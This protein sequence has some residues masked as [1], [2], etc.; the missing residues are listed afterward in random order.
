MNTLKLEIEGASHAPEIRFSLSGMPEFL[1]DETKLKS[2]MSRRAPG[3]SALVSARKETDDVHWT[4]AGGV[5]KG[6]ILNTDFRSE[7]YCKEPVPRPGHA[8]FTQYLNSGFI[9]SGGGKSSGRLTAAYCALGGVALQFLEARGILISAKIA[10]IGGKTGDFDAVIQAAANE[11]DSIGG[12]VECTVE[13]LP[14]GLGGDLF[15]GLESQLAPLIFG[16]PGVKGLEFGSGFA[17][18]TLRGSENNDAFRVEKGRVI[19]DTNN[20]GGILG[21]RSTGMPLKFKVAFKPTPS[22]SKPQTSVNLETL[23]P[24]TIVTQGRHDPCIVL[25]A[26]PVVEAVTALALADVILTTEQRTPRICEVMNDNHHPSLFADMMEIKGDFKV[27]SNLP[28]IT[29]VKAIHDFSGP[30]TGL[31]E[32]LRALRKTSSDIPKIAF[33][34]HHLSD[35]TAAYRELKA[36]KLSFPYIFVAMGKLGQVSRI[37]ASRFGSAYMY[38]SAEKNEIGLLSPEAMVKTYRFRSI[39]EETALFAVTGWP[40]KTTKSPELHNAVFAEEDRN[41]VMFPLPSE[42]AEEAVEFFRVVGLKG[43][44][45][46]IPHKTSIIPLL[47][48]IDP[49]AEAVGAVNTVVKE[50]TELVGYNT[51][52]EGFAEVMGE[53][54]GLKVALLG[55]GGAAKAV[56]YALKRAGAQVEVFH[57]RKLTP[58][59]DLIVNATPVDPIPEYG[60]CGTE[61]VI[62]LNYASN[63]SPLLSGAAAAGCKVEDGLAMLRAQASAQRRLFNKTIEIQG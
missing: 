25:R 37:L 2:F 62:D 8:D 34:P 13:N 54:A 29:G 20:H 42:T 48:R 49:L 60:F 1:I 47:D 16:I 44:A 40:L 56:K 15:D 5:L 24:Q 7:D 51:D 30:I 57:R 6:E 28:V 10:T 53:V 3:K 14:A 18:A 35:V 61:R 11:G 31:A 36:A 46:T 52:V 41:A 59:F 32:K 43:M 39:N 19:T 4:R 27:D 38:A 63:L 33:M 12:V 23:T 58:G 45:V 55:D 26:I 17:G 9:P 22:I 50:G 21:G